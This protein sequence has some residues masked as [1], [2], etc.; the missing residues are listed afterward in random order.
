MKIASLQ[1]QIVEQPLKVAFDIAGGKSSS[2]KSVLVQMTDDQ[3]LSGY[4]E[5]VPMPAYSGQT[6]QGVVEALDSY[7]FPA[8]L[9]G[10]V[11]SIEQLHELMAQTIKEQPMAKAAIDLA[12]HDLVARRLG[13]PV[14][15]LLGG[16][17]RERVSLSWAIGLGEPEQLV[18]E[19]REMVEHGFRTI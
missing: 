2:V 5:A 12:Y 14:Y 4:G 17:C 19:A 15:E 8:L 7:L 13:V 3:G 10:D 9:A 16:R 6:I 18:Q 11:H 1:L